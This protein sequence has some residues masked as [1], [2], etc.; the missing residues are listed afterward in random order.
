MIFSGWSYVMLALAAKKGLTGGVSCFKVFGGNE[1]S[2]PAPV[3]QL[4]RATD[5]ESVCRGFESIIGDHLKGAP[6]HLRG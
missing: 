3:A 5:Y 6:T 4:D 2:K 1:G